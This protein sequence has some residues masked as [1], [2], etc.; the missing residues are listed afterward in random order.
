MKRKLFGLALSAIVATG[1]S[2][3]PR[4]VDPFSLPSSSRAEVYR[5]VQSYMEAA[6]HSD[7]ETIMS[8]ILR[9][10]EVLSVA[11]GAVTEGWDAIREKVERLNEVPADIH[12]ILTGD[13]FQYQLGPDSVLVVA[14]YTVRAARGG[15]TLT[16][17]AVTTLVLVR[18]GDAWKVLHEHNSGNCQKVTD[19]KSEKD[20]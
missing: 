16:L 9:N 4:P 7:L 5:F 15:R 19:M 14:P 6:N 13:P 2:H 11:N 1:C 3:G 17:Q 12:V 10:P 18:A 8:M 20:Q